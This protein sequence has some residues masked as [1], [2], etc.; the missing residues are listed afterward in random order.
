[1]TL[2][3]EILFK[4]KKDLWVFTAAIL[5]DYVTCKKRCDI[6]TEITYEFDIVGLPGVRFR[7]LVAWYPHRQRKGRMDHG[8]FVLIF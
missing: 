8:K 7:R 3:G 5:I 2:I 1:M 4:E 6:T